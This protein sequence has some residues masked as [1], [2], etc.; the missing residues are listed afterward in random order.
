MLDGRYR[1]FL[2]LFGGYLTRDWLLGLS[3]AASALSDMQKI[4]RAKW[5]REGLFFVITQMI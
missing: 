1:L 2:C 4:R 3:D 5:S